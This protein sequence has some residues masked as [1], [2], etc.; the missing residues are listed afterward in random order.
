MNQAI[1]ILDS[2]AYPLLVWAIYVERVDAPRL[3][4]APDEA[5]IA[6]TL[7][8]AETCLQALEEVMG[9]GPWLAGDDLSLADLHA[10]PMVDLFRRAPEGAAMLAR[11]P[12]LSGWLER[13]TARPSFAAT[14]AS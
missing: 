8:R 9:D 2:Y 11:R 6:A 10:A 7:P 12:R 1:G 14:A 4:R 13:I 3:G 5:K